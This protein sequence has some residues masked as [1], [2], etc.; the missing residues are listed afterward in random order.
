MRRRFS[1]TLGVAALL[2]LPS[3]ANAQNSVSDDDSS[4]LVAGMAQS[5][6][7]PS[8]SSGHSQGFG[9]GVKGGP[10]FSK[11]QEAN[12]NFSNNTGFEGGIFFG[13]NRPGGVGVMGEVLYAKKGSKDASGNVTVDSY[14]LEIPILLR[15]NIGSA[16]KNTGVLVYGIGGPVFDV[17]LKSQQNGIDVKSNYES[18]DLGI[19]GGVGIEVSRFLVEGRYNWA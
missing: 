5:Q 3:L 4:F 7:Q 12:T 13:G 17:L 11:F 10:I 9:I 15:V 8:R 6:N 16:N 14:Y 2:C 1:L 18:L 19:I